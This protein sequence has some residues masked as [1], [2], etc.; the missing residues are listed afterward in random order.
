MFYTE[1]M[2]NE[3]SRPIILPQALLDRINQKLTILEVKDK[4]V[5]IK[6]YESIVS[7]NI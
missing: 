7:S 5:V 1:G 2:H 4:F 3:D 6:R